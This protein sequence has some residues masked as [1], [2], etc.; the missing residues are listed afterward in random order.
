MHALESLSGEVE[1]RPPAFSAV[2]VGGRRAYDLARTG[3]G[4]TLAPRRVTIYDIDCRQWAPPILALRV[5]CSSGTYIRALARDLGDL[6]GVGASLSRLVR[7]R[8]GP[9]RL[10]E[11]MGLSDIE[12]RAGAALLGPDVLLVDRPAVALEASQLESFRHGRSW[13]ARDVGAAV[14]RAYTLDGR[15]AGLL[16]I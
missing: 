3:V 9:F 4:V 15:F 7:L 10:R 12:Q 16:D 13:S 14:A 11:S 6:L 1:Q 2:K 5:R 8:V